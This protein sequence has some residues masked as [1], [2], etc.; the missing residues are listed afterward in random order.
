MSA[1]LHILS[2]YLHSKVIIGLKTQ[3]TSFFQ[4]LFEAIINSLDAQATKIDIVSG[5]A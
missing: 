3:P 2:K 5:S 1:Y 4:P